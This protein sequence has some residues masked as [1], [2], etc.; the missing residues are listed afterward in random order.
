MK[1][2]RRNPGAKIFG[3][4]LLPP[5]ILTS[6][7]LPSLLLI[8]PTSSP[9]ISQ[10]TP[11]VFLFSNWKTSHRSQPSMVYQVVLDGTKRI[12]GLYFTD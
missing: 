9:P 11:P 5:Y 6:V 3:K 2:Q 8:P 7:S 1:G 12:K 10:P 4:V